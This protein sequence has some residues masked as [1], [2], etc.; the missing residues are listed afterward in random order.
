MEVINIYIHKVFLCFHLLAKENLNNSTLYP[1]K[2]QGYGLGLRM[3]VRV[4]S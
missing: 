4:K 1:T 3:L 2:E